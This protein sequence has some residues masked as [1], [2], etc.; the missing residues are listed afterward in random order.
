VK[1]KATPKIKHVS[2]K[3]RAVRKGEEEKEVH[4]TS[5]DKQKV[6]SAPVS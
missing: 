5:V 3:D 6:Q 2:P 4:V 1:G